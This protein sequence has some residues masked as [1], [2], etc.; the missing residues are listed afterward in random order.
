MTQIQKS[1]NCFSTRL[2]SFL[3]LT[4]LG[5][6]ASPTPS[7]TEYAVR[8]QLSVLKT[9]IDRLYEEAHTIESQV[10]EVRR[11]PMDEKLEQLNRLEAQ[12]QTLLA[13]YENCKREYLRL[14]DLLIVKQSRID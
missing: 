12:R 6:T 9:Q 3:L 8:S 13:E 5:C 2:G 11:A 4:L 1:F 7:S 10:D 14:Q